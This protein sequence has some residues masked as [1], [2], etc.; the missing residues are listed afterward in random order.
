MK[1]L[2]FAGALVAALA[3]ASA[4]LAAT[5][6]A[7]KDTSLGANAGFRR[8]VSGNDQY[9]LTENDDT[10]VECA[11]RIEWQQPL[12][13][14][15]TPSQGA[16]WIGK[17]YTGQ[18]TYCAYLAVT[19]PLQGVDANYRFAADLLY[20]GTDG[21]VAGSFPVGWGNITANPG[22]RRSI[23][24]KPVA[25]EF[26]HNVVGKWRLQMRVTFTDLSTARDYTM[27]GPVTDYNPN[28]N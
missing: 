4:A 18:S 23:N 10:H 28:Y 15:G 14:D 6:Y 24:M 13:Q 25:E 11:Y 21:K 27:F 22:T 8:V 9:P 7:T 26:V 1:R 5:Y 3:L 20:I 17:P 19:A 2:G 12:Y 16:F